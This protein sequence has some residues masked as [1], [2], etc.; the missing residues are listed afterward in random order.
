MFNLL[1]IINFDRTVEIFWYERKPFGYNGRCV[2]SEHYANADQAVDAVLVDDDRMQIALIDV[3]VDEN[4]SDQA[5]ATL[6]SIADRFC[7]RLRLNN[8]RTRKTY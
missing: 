7:N 3:D 1:T 2:R 4:G 6:R 8:L 5:L